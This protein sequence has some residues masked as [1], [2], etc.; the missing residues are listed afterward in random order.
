MGEFIR[1][2]SGVKEA[3]YNPTLEPLNLESGAVAVGAADQATIT[4]PNPA[5]SRHK[6]RYFVELAARGGDVTFTVDG[7]VAIATSPGYLPEDSR[8]WIGPLDE[9]TQHIVHVYAI[10]AA[11]VHYYWWREM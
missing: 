2:A 8:E 11:T 5:G 4:G 9:A 1:Y 7:G 10:S 6:G 3:V